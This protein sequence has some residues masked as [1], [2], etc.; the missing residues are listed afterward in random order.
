MPKLIVVEGSSRRVARRQVNCRSCALAKLCLPF[1]LSLSEIEDLDKLVRRSRPMEKGEFLF[2]QGEEFRSVF[3]IRTGTVKNYHITNTGVEQITG[4][5]LP[6]ELLGLAGMDGGVYPVSA[7]TLE[8]TS[9][10]EIPFD[11][12]DELVD[13]IP[14]LRRQLMR[15]MSRE[16]REDQQ[17]MLL[18]SKKTS[19]ERVATFL[20]NLSA[21]F[22]SRGYSA[23]ILRLSMSRGEIGN[24]LGV[25]MET[26]S[27]SFAKL[28]DLGLI[29]VSGR[30][31]EIVDSGGLCEL[32]GGGG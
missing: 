4:F 19:E 31:I 14:K 3:A 6:S 25:A 15:I 2:R 13:V 5:Q 28:Q 1:S 16:I 9:V 30:D 12:L 18:L 32:A 26:V 23:K 24:Y 7:Q 17:M 11:R 21:R 22:R 20:L 8:S 27:R 10:C 29:R